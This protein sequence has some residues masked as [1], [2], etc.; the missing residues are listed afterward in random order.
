[1][2]RWLARPG[3]RHW[4]G[5]A[6]LIVLIPGVT[7]SLLLQY[8]SIERQRAGELRADM[9]LA[10]AAA[11]AFEAYVQD[12]LHHALAVGLAVPM[13]L[14]ESVERANA[15]LAAN[16]AGSPAV[17][18]FAWVDPSGRVVAA[19]DPTQVGVS[20]A[21]RDYFRAAVGGAEQV[22]S[23][24]LVARSG[25]ASFVIVRPIHDRAE[26]R[27]VVVAV[28]DP[29]RLG[30]VL[31][32]AR[33]DGGTVGIVDRRGAVVY[34]HPGPELSWDERLRATSIVG[35]ALGDRGVERSGLAA[36]PWAE[37]AM[38]V[39]VSP[40]RSVGWA[41]VAGRPAGA[42]MAPLVRDALQNL[43]VLLVVWALALVG[44]LAIA[45]RVTRPIRALRTH[46]GAL[47]RGQ[48]DRRAA[49]VGPV[50]VQELALAINAMADA[51]ADREREREQ[52]VHAISH[53]LRSPLAAIM[54]NAQ[55]LRR[56]QERDDADERQRRRAAAIEAS[57]E[58]LGGMIADLVDAARLEGGQL[59]VAPVP[60]DLGRL[61]ADVVARMGDGEAERVVVAAPT[62]LPLAAADPARI[63]R[64]LANLIG[65]ALKYSPA[66]APVRVDVRS[67][68][69]EVLVEVADLG[70]GIAPE[71]LPRLFQRHGRT[72]SGRGRADSLGLGLYIARGIVEAHGGRVWVES[73]PEAGSTFGFAVPVAGAPEVP[74]T[75]ERERAE[76]LR[77][78]TDGSAAPP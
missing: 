2:G 27:G 21:G 53:D 66:S 3:M 16:A 14:D 71:E 13:A 57:A 62:G 70:P 42:V 75:G 63:E 6:L 34:R 40:V 43:A 1:V 8:R 4:L 23:D 31:A 72:A 36:L 55:L 22:V 25:G 50:E 73:A 58:R 29:A 17:R 5:G 56:A 28:V 76:P 41:V 65:N 47:G 10:R 44:A 18:D 24:L 37:G 45:R 46:A 52:Y 19:S 60:V 74:A 7:A 11:T 51:L 78:L 64:V 38:T 69:R 30:E 9:E 59:R 20:V 68:G 61:A 48:L 12:V 77:L 33:A 67:R 39:G 26:L 54:A 32:F 49:V 35:R 15:Y